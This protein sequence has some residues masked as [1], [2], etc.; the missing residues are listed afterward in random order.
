MHLLP[1]DILIESEHQRTIEVLVEKDIEL[2]TGHGEL[3]GEFLLTVAV[4]LVA[5]GCASDQMQ[6]RG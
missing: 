1:P 2:E 4:G 6:G 3:A 5:D